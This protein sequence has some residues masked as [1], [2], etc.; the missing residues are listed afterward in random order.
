MLSAAR[1]ATSSWASGSTASGRSSPWASRWSSSICSG[2]SAGN[3]ALADLGGIKLIQY[4][5]P[6]FVAYGVMAAC[7][8]MLAITMVVRRETGLLK[9]LRLSPLPDLGAADRHLRQPAIVATVQVVL[10]LAIGRPAIRRAPA[11]ATWRRS[12]WPS[13]VGMVSFTA[14]GVAMSTLIPNQDAAGPVTSIVFFVL[15][16][17]SG[18]WFPLTPS[19]G[20]AKF[21]PLVPGPPL[22]PGRATPRSTPSRA[23]RRGTGTT[24]NGWPCGGCSAPWWRCAASSGPRDG[25]SC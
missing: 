12:W 23:R 13:L 2:R 4:Y 9:R 14:L 18:L 5:V 10:L 15:L 21:S 6:G 8:T 3:A 11:R 20:L 25:A 17:L 1:S 16:F 19:S 22:H 7:F 24:S